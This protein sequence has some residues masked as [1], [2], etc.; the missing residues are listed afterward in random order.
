[1]SVS[2]ASLKSRFEQ[3][4]HVESY[5]DAEFL[6]W[7]ENAVRF[8]SRYNPLIQTTDV[9]AVEDQ[10]DYSLPADC[11][12]VLD[13]L[14]VPDSLVGTLSLEN[15][16]DRGGLPKTD[17]ARYFAE[18]MYDAVGRLVPNELWE[19]RGLTLAFVAP[20][21]SSDETFQVT[22]TAVHVLTGSAP[23]QVYAT[24]P[25]DDFDVLVGL[26]MADIIESRAVEAAT[27]EDFAE[28][29]GRT[30]V[31]FIPGGTTNMTARLRAAL[32]DKYTGAV[33]AQGV[34]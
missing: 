1:M 5:D 23:N 28:G 7:L 21:E 33:I 6:D 32:T 34:A 16:S 30:T 4:Y 3:R 11:V 14:N 26:V 20:F 9:D 22:Y 8:Y 31:H 18:K 15:L 25:T 27:T 12:M 19:Q 24:I 13:A 10:A 2:V 17:P 29:L